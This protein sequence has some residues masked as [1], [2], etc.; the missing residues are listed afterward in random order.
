VSLNHATI[1]H[2]SKDACTITDH[3]SSYGTFVGDVRLSPESPRL[4]R[5]GDLL[6]I[7]GVWLELQIARRAAGAP[8]ATNELALALVSDVVRASKSPSVIVVE[9]PDLGSEIELSESRVY[10]VGR[11]EHCDLRLT[12]PD[13]SREHA[14][15]ERRGTDF[16]LRNPGAR[17]GVRLGQVALESGQESSW[18]GGT[19][20]RIGRS[21]LS[22]EIP[23]ERA[24]IVLHEPILTT[25]PKQKHQASTARPEE[26]VPV[27]VAPPSPSLP[28]SGP[29]EP[30]SP[31]LAPSATAPGVDAPLV[32]LD[33][34]PVRPATATITRGDHAGRLLIFAIISVMLL[35]AGLLVVLLRGG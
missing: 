13:A 4:V 31:P 2:I 30:G 10:R 28:L 11:G 17:N 32:Q 29:E 34:A 26:S 20:A 9:G 19:A 16:F 33:L 8:M 15:V 14:L 3:G 7:G 25:P 27:V 1:E 24:E 6:R 21:V 18:S 35:A 22:L 12:D 23:S 5:S